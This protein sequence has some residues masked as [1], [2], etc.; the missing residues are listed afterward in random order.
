MDEE[1]LRKLPGQTANRMM[2]Y[3]H[4][5][6]RVATARFGEAA[7]SRDPMITVTLASAMLQMESAEVMAEALR[8][9]TAP[10]PDE[11]TS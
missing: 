3:M 4:Q 1:Q 5:A 6:N 2:K 7:V 8:G 11:E 9:A 10:L